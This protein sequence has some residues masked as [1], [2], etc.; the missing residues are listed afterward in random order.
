MTTLQINIPDQRAAALT[1]Y[2]EA[3]GLTV[4]QWFL[5]LAERVAPSSSEPMP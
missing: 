5:Q 4:E 2:A 3:R 1:A